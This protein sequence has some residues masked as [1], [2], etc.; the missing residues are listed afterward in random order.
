MQILTTVDP[1][2][3]LNHGDVITD[4]KITRSNPHQNATWTNGHISL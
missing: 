2:Q 3:C 4:L 1:Y